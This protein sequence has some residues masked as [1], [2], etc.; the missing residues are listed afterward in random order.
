MDNS[1]LTSWVLSVGFVWFV[2]AVFLG[3]TGMVATL[4]PPFPQILVAALTV[5]LLLAFSKAHSFRSWINGLPMQA[6]LLP[7]AV[8]FVGFYFLALHAQGKLP[9]AFAVPGGW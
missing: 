9:F 2:L 3:A 6:L 1:N 8:R 4:R 5:G 7:H